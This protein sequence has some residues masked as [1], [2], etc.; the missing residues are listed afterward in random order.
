MH[1]TWGVEDELDEEDEADKVGAEDVA[2]ACHSHNTCR[3]KRKD[4]VDVATTVVSR[5]HQEVQE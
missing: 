5:S 1:S 2:N 4:K 3:T